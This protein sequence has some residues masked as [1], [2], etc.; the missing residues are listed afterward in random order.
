LMISDF[1]LVPTN[2]DFFSVMAINSL[3]KILPNWSAWAK[4]A[5][6]HPVLQG[7]VYPFPQVTL[8][9]LGTIL[10][11][12]RI[13][14]G[15]ETAAF[16]SWIE[17]IE[18]RVSEQF[19]PTLKSHGLLLPEHLYTEQEMD[20]SCT[21]SKISNFNSLIALSQKYG[22]P[23]YDLTKDQTD[24]SGTAW[25]TTQNNQKKF[26]ETFSDLADKIIALSSAHAVR[27]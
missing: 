25:E 15:Q 16:K 14:N 11:N 9:F 18:K 7:A 1:F 4:M 8:K 6:Q 3:S 19:I 20:N 2:A 26:Q 5:S 27:A 22:T 17:K 10:Q 13:R 21:L 12:Y 24:L 23:I